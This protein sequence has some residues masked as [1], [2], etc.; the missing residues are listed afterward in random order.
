MTPWLVS[1]AIAKE[2]TPSESDSPMKTLFL[3]AALAATGGLS[4]LAQTNGPALTVLRQS[5]NQVKLTITNAV[6]GVAYELYRT[7]VLGD[8]L[9]YPWTLEQLGSVNQTNFYS[10]SDIE[11][12]GFYKATTADWDSDGIPNYQDAQPNN[13]AVGRLTITIQ[14]PTNGSTVN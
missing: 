11:A 3:A 12:A 6:V 9:N 7:P 8:E 1:P 2:Q 10:Y 14:F 4:V 13:A 5:T